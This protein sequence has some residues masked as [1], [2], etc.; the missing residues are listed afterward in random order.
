MSFERFPS[1][2]APQDPLDV[3][4]KKLDELI[5]RKKSGEETPALN[6]ELAQTWER[7]AKLNGEQRVDE[8]NPAE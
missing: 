5:V 4:R 1:Q 2:E 7:F 8:R 3:L 6:E